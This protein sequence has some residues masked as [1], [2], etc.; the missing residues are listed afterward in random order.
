MGCPAI[1]CFPECLEVA[2]G[3]GTGFSLVDAN[4]WSGLGAGAH[5][6][7]VHGLPTPCS[8]C[9][10]MAAS[11]TWQQPSLDRKTPGYRKSPSWEASESLDDCRKQGTCSAGSLTSDN[12]LRKKKCPLLFKPLNY[13]HTSYLNLTIIETKEILPPPTGPC[14]DTAFGSLF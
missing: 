11:G 13:Y 9:L 7:C 3:H 8:L 14:L 10:F 4:K 1:L 12:Y 2:H 5:K 6:K